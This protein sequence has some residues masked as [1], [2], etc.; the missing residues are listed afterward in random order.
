MRSIAKLVKIVSDIEKIIIM[1]NF[2]HFE[3]RRVY[4]RNRYSNRIENR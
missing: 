2:R 3:I 1:I 4:R